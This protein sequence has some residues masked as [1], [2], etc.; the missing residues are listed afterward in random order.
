MRRGTRRVTVGLL[1]ALAAAGGI[2]G[3]AQAALPDGRGYELVSPAVK[4]GGVGANDFVIAPH[5]MNDGDHFL[6]PGIVPMP[7]AAN[8]AR[9]DYVASR[10]P[11]GWTS[12]AQLP[13]LSSDFGQGMQ[14]NQWTSMSDDG[15]T[16]LYATA[17]NLDPADDDYN[18]SCCNASDLYLRTADGSFIW[19]SR[20]DLNTNSPSNGV[21]DGIV[22][23]DG[24]HVVFLSDLPLLAEDATRTSGRGIYV[25]HD[26]QISL[27]SVAPDGTALNPSIG[28]FLGSTAQQAVERTGVHPISD[29]GSRIFFTTDARVYVWEEGKGTR[30]LGGSPQP[31]DFEDF[32][33]AT[34]DGS[35]AWF[36]TNEAL[37][38]DD[39]D[40]TVDLYEWRASDGT[41]RRLSGGSSGT[42]QDANVLNAR[43]RA[44]D[45]GARVYFRAFGALAPGAPD[46]PDF[47]AEEN[48]FLR[49]GDVTKYVATLNA[50]ELQDVP[51]CTSGEWRSSIDGEH[52]LIATTTPVDPADTDTNIDLYRYSSATGVV[53][54]VSTGPAGGNG[55]LDADLGL[56][57]D[58]CGS[59]AYNEAQTMSEDGR[60]V[61]FQTDEKLVA[62]D[63]NG[64][65]DVYERD[66]QTETTSLISSGTS[67][68]RS[69][70]LGVAANGRDVFFSTFD[71]LVPQDEDTAQDVYDARIEGG[72]RVVETPL[73]SGDQCQGQAHPGDSPLATPGSATYQ[74]RIVPPTTT[75]KKQTLAV[76]RLS[77]KQLR[78]L[79]RTGKVKLR[80]RAARA[81]TVR[82]LG[83]STIR[84]KRVTVLRRSAKVQAGRTTSVTVRLSATARKQL[85]GK[86]V[87]NVRLNVSV[88]SGAVVK[89]ATLRLR[90]SRT[91]AAKRAAATSLVQR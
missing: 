39:H 59:P 81:G 42:E 74:R 61:F 68:F 5:A 2:A 44:S 52:L 64:V 30:A 60:Y 8:G 21:Q 49:E 25:W 1:S 33:G 4:Y 15:R 23:A 7:G 41:V 26:G 90:L 76:T 37:T 20:G 69:S 50:F 82:I 9:N 70:L 22:S 45:D 14:F 71:A 36:N 72:F 55:G 24:S 40:S 27:V 12:V 54:L 67:T 13:A 75:P 18:G 85:A 63:V 84:G 83:R 57:W 47:G 6:F 77:A 62:A 46:L 34:A 56:P 32:A 58:D 31:S 48:L 53:E 88:S 87:L 29:D 73:C 10:G 3:G 43:V 65:R 19:I 79:A 35:K 80:V 17:Q 11:S 16:I 38:A 86:R 78:Q 91:S 51:Y 28:T 66:V 89:T